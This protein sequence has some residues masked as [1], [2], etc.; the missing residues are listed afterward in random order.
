MENPSTPN[1][2]Q[3]QERAPTLG[4]EHGEGCQQHPLQPCVP[5]ALAK[6]ISLKGEEEAPI[7]RPSAV[8]EGKAVA[9]Q[10]ESLGL[11]Q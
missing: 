9:A 4:Q 3:L 5:N 7:L 2:L 11:G 10:T 8:V 6:N 1:R